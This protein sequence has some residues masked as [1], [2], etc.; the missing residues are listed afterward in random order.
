MDLP[1]AFNRHVFGQLNGNPFDGSFGVPGG[2]GHSVLNSPRQIQLTL[3]Y[4]F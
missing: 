1:N 3:R 4:E 2:G